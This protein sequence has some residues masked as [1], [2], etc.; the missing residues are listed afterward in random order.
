MDQRKL[1]PIQEWQPPTQIR[2]VQSFLGFSNF[3][4]RFIKGFSKIV[5]VALTRKDRP[6]CWTLAEQSTFMA[7]K[8]AFMIAPILLHPDPTKPFIVET[9]V[10]N[11][12]ISVIL[13]QPDNDGVHH[14]IAYYSHTFTIP[15]INYLIYDKELAAIISAFEEWR[16]YLVGPQHCSGR[17]RPQNLLYFSST[18]ILNRRQA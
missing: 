2:D 15:K 12:V 8:Y 14:P 5:L 1:A 13:S 17:N 11:F 9:D 16:P 6:F 7:L 10:S 4:R 3:Y 18:R